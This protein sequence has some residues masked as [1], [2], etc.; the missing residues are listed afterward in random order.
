MNVLAKH[1]ERRKD[2]KMKRL[3][4]LGFAFF[5]ISA[6][7][8]GQGKESKPKVTGETKKV[9]TKKYMKRNVADPEI[10]IE[11]DEGAMKLELFPDVAPAHVDSMLSLIKKGFYNGLT[12]HRIIDGFMIQG[13]DP[14]GDG[15]GNAGYNLPAEF[16]QLKHIEGTL[17]MARAQ[18]PNSA[19]C[20][21]FIC[22]AAAPHLDGKYT[23][24]GQLME[25]TEALHKIGKV[26]VQGD[27]P[28]KPVFIRKMTV[29]KDKPEKKT[30]K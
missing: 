4:Y 27:R 2:D 9:E 16:S 7:A 29:L 28:V 3:L 15:S 19:S 10:A 25:G 21:F 18:D 20:Q 14:K 5:F 13:G 26:Q 6:V 22:L 11:T 8:F 23:I 24:F 1:I 17:S 12:F 30:E